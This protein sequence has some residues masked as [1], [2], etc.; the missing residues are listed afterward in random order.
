MTPFVV[1]LPLFAAFAVLAAVLLTQAAPPVAA[2]GP[3]AERMRSAALV[4]QTRTGNHRFT[5]EVARTGRQHATGLMY[6]RRLARDAGMLFL[7][8]V[9]EPVIMWMKNTFIPLDMLFLA[10][11]GRIMSMAQRTVPHSTANIPS[12][13]PVMAVLEVNGGTVARLGISIGDRVIHPAFAGSR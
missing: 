7:Y 11:D 6:R 13:G 3:G 1:R 9:S 2:Q 5:V 10:G 4:I 8:K 12:G